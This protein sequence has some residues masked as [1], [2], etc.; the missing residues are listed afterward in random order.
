MK[1]TIED[2]LEKFKPLGKIHLHMHDDFTYSAKL[3]LFTKS[4][5]VEFKVESG[6]NIKTPLS[7]LQTVGNRLDKVMSAISQDKRIEH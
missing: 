2:L 6:F 7:A 5:G 3:E 1:Q 4:E